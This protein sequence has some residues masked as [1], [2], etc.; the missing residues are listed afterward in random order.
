MR[1]RQ[2]IPIFGL[3]VLLLPAYVFAQTQQPEPPPPP[4]P[5]AQAGQADSSN[6]KKSSSRHQ[7]DFLVKGTVFTPEGLS[8]AGA[9]IRIR[10]AGAKSFHWQSEANSRG[11]FAIRVVQ[12]AKYEVFVRAKGFKEQMK[13]ADG[14]GSERIEEMV[15]HMEREGGKPQ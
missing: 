15:F 1:G 5:A 8:F 11:E 9:E 3:A 10:K 13:P 7:H 2:L 4:A 14:M 12:G 6:N